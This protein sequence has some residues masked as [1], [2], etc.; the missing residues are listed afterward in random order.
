MAKNV[1]IITLFRPGHRLIKQLR[2]ESESSPHVSNRGLPLTE[3]KSSG[4]IDTW[5]FRCENCIISIY[6]PN[7]TFC[8]TFRFEIGPENVMKL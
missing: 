4:G 1:S 7:S 8:W 6:G 2:M 5:S 3:I